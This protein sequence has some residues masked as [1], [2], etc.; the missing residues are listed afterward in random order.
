M[1]LTDKLAAYFKQRPN[2]AISAPEL[3]AHFGYGGWRS[4]VVDA[5]CKY[6][7][8]IRN[9]QIRRD[10]KIYSF[11]RYVPD[12]PVSV[13]EQKHDANSWGLR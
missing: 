9:E 10:G 12:A 8:D 6:G 2:E 1:S 4:R 5:R 13:R 7:M 11:Y 3:A